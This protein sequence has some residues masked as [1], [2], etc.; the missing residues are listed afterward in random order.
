VTNLIIYKLFLLLNVIVS[1]EQVVIKNLNNVKFE[2][3][4]TSYVAQLIKL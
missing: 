2:F 1:L 4:I 3:D